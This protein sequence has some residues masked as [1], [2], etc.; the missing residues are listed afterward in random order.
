MS[1]DN[2][3]VDLA[4]ILAQFTNFVMNERVRSFNEGIDDER[5]RC[6]KPNALTMAGSITREEIEERVR[7]DQDDFDYYTRQ[8]EASSA[9]ACEIR[10]EAMKAQLRVADQQ[11]VLNDRLA[12]IDRAIRRPR[13]VG[14][15]L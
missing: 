15:P 1:Q 3:D 7:Y 2:P 13:H 10:L 14:G 4:E 11:R 8:G 9:R 12:E 5:E 6:A